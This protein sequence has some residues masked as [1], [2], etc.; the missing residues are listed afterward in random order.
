M[1]LEPH[2]DWALRQRLE[3]DTPLHVHEQ[4]IEIEILTSRLPRQPSLSPSAKR[5]HHTRQF[6][7]G[8]SQSVFGA[9]SPIDG[10]HSA[11]QDQ[12]LQPLREQ[13]A[14]DARYA[15]A[16]LVEAPAPAQQLACNEQGPPAAHNF[17]GARYG[18]ELT[19]TSHGKMLSMLNHDP[20]AV[21]DRQ[22]QPV[23]D[24]VRTDTCRAVVDAK[25]PLINRASGAALIAKT[26]CTDRKTLYGL[27]TLSWYYFDRRSKIGMEFAS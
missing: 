14:R 4:G 25:D 27:L 15:T 8:P 24:L 2:D 5:A 22:N 12:C 13:G 20:V 7:A 26:R 17:E 9:I 1:H 16:N 10:C 6:L 18:A 19:I 21:L 23:T 11:D 3:A